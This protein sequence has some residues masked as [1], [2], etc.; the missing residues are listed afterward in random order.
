MSDVYCG[1]SHRCQPFPFIQHL[2]KCQYGLAVTVSTDAE[3]TQ[4][5][6]AVDPDGSATVKIYRHAKVLHKIEVEGIPGPQGEPESSA[7]Q[8]EGGKG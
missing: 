8:P 7:R 1:V 2:E 5:S 4:I 3:T 6:L